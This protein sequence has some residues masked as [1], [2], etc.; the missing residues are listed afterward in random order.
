MIRAGAMESFKNNDSDNHYGRE[1]LVKR[2]L[3][4]LAISLTHKTCRS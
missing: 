2:M 4:Q 3:P 1:P